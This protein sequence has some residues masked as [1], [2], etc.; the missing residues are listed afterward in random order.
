MD[1]NELSEH[2]RAISERHAPQTRGLITRIVSACWPGGSPDRTERAASQW[3]R[4]W[5]PERAGATLPM[6]TCAAGHCPVCN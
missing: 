6:C 1:Q 5:R 3:L 2:I 4:R